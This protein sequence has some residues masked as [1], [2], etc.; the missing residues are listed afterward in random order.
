MMPIRKGFL[1]VK[2]AP[3]SKPPLFLAE[4]LEGKRFLTF[5]E[6]CTY[7][8]NTEEGETMEER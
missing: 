7:I 3:E 5:K 1:S 6:I 4:R 2:W 8:N